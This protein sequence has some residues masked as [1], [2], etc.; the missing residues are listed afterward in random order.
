MSWSFQW[1][2]RFEDEVDVGG[3]PSTVTDPQAFFA[4]R[5]WP[6]VAK[7]KRIVGL[8]ELDFVESIRAAPVI[9]YDAND[10]YR[11][12]GSNGLQPGVLK[13][14]ELHLE[15]IKRTIMVL[16]SGLIQRN[17]SMIDLALRGYETA[18][19]YQG[20]VGNFPTQ[21]GTGTADNIHHK[22]IGFMALL[23]VVSILREAAIPELNH[24][25][26]ALLAKASLT[27]KWMASSGD[28]V[29]LLTT[30]NAGNQLMCVVACMYQGAALLGDPSLLEVARRFRATAMARVYREDGA[31]T[32]KGGLDSSYLTVSIETMIDILCSM[33]EEER[34]AFRP[35]LLKTV[36]KFLSLIERDGTLCMD[37]NTR[38][39]T[40]TFVPGPGPKGI[41]IDVIPLRLYRIG[42]LY[43]ENKVERVGDLVMLR[44]QGPDHIED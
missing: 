29:E 8:S 10:I 17:S 31:I 2:I 35:A 33:P 43:G 7:G 3:I 14:G 13:S 37:E 19:G 18:I 20:A 36:N 32:E 16:H 12:L 40:V 28:P 39:Q 23:K 4:V 38:T 15:N 9:V 21:G 26:E 27:L 25:V 24:R 30:G 1:P 41:N 34:E 5:E 42:N 44:G 22:S 6:L 11:K